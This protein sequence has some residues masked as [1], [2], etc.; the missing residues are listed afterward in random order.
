MAN[1]FVTGASGFIGKRLVNALLQQNHTVYALMR[2]KGTQ[3]LPEEGARLHLLFGDLQDERVLDALPQDIDAAY[4]LMH[5]MSDISHGLLELEKTIATN[6]V[7]AL[8]KTKVKQLIYLGGI[9]DEQRLSIHLESRKMV[10]EILKASQIPTTVLRASIIIGSGSASFEII[11]DLVEKLPLMVAPKWVNN[12]CQ[13][14]AVYDVLYYLLQ[15]MLNEGCYRRTF[16]IGGPDV[17]TFKEALLEYANM[18]NLKRYIISVPV[19]TPRLSSYWLVF[20]TSVRFSL[21]SYLVESM[22]SNTACQN[23]LI[24]TIIPHKCLTYKEALEMAFLKT[25]QNEVTSTWMDSW[26]I[27]TKHPDIQSYIQVP[28]EGVLWNRQEVAIIDSPEAA[29]QRIWTI[30]GKKGWYGFEWAWNMRGMLDKLLGG[31]GMNRGRRHPQEILVG[32]SI[33]F[34]RVLKAD[35]QAKHLILYAEMKLPGEAWLE[36]QIQNERLV[37]TATFRPKGVWGRLYWYLLTP[38]HFFL[39]RNM[40]RQIA[41]SKSIK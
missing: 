35:V 23:S 34:W 19:L 4:Y 22:K 31:V 26:E 41:G 2:I 39:F 40:A 11:R 38:I 33:D 36:F 6:F 24:Q 29:L 28:R 32:D 30:G 9:L 13:P 10:E 27:G 18:R 14:I 1:I 15:V 8:K 3:L 17:L 20:I 21:A 7:K 12:L 37:Q 16:D 25:A 5:S